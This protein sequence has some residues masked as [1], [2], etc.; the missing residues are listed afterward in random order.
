[1]SVAALFV[2]SFAWALGKGNGFGGLVWLA[3][4][5]ALVLTGANGND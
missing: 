4:V 5:I 2:L 3:V 1:M